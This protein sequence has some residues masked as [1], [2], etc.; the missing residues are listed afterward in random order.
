[1]QHILVCVTQQKTCERLIKKGAELKKDFGGELFVIHV[2]KDG[3]NFLD[4]PMQNDALEYLF[5]ISKEYEASMT[6]LRSNN[7]VEAIEKFAKENDI[8]QIVLGAAPG[9]VKENIILK[10][11]YEKLPKCEFHI[12]NN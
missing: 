7:V 5:D 9:D 12:V 4:N 10:G 1:M 8:S 3:D 2:A 6:V 11:L